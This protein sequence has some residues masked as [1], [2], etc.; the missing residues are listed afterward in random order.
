[1]RPTVLFPCLASLVLSGNLLAQQQVEPV[2]PE[3]ASQTETI[4][5]AGRDLRDPKEEVRLGAA[6]LLGKYKTLRSM[7][8]LA[9]SPAGAS[10]TAWGLN[11]PSVRVRRAVVVSFSEFLMS[12]IY[13]NN[14]SLLERF[15]EKLADP[16][17][18][19]R[20]QV[21]EMLPG[22]GSGLF[23]SNYQVVEINGQRVFRS[24]PYALP[25]KLATIVQRAFQDE[26]PIV[27]QTMLKYF[28]VL[29]IPLPPLTL[30]R[31]LGDEDRGVRMAA[32]DRVTMLPPH[33]AVFRKLREMTKHEDVGVRQKVA[34]IARSSSHRTSRDILRSLRDDED[35]YV[36][37]LAVTS[38][39]RLGEPQP[40]AMVEKV[41]EFLM[42]TSSTSNQVVS[43]V[44]AVSAFGSHQSQIIFR[45]LTE[46]DAP[47]I[48][49]IAWQRFL[50][51]DNGWSNPKLWLPALQD[52]DRKTRET[53]T[54]IV[55]SRARTFDS[56]TMTALVGNSY[57]DVR[58]FAAD[59]LALVTPKVADEFRFDLLIDEKTE[60]RA[61]ALRSVGIRRPSNWLLILER[62]LLD[63]ESMI[64]RVALEYLLNDR[65]QGIPALIKFSR[66][67]PRNPITARIRVELA[68]RNVLI[69]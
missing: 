28:Y 10:G 33:D 19:V 37:T 6:K 15:L 43:L 50:G 23:R 47:K 25:P 41:R 36:M 24:T 13:A 1:M 27:R 45:A 60:V 56:K 39:A 26:D 53:I 59:C 46:H 3:R 22:L 42:G 9:G 17:I 61:A 58:R 16:D 57:V 62:S 4:E 35:P 51:Y 18:E 68:S 64:Q 14:R 55:V 34:S 11:D 30:E 21:S 29:R 2:A 69:P 44:Y 12:G 52:R 49:R 31:L 8:L 48:R 7:T 20:R 66:K 32:L 5:R 54:S 67:H 63:E 40:D 65:A 38:L